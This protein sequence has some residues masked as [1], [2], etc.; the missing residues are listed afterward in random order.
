MIV[1]ANHI[2][3]QK[4]HTMIYKGSCH[5]GAIAFEANGDIPQVIECNCSI[6]RR[7]GY[8]LWFVPRD[9][10]TLNKAES[11]MGTYTFNRHMIR[12]HFCPKCGVATFGMTKDPKGHEMVAI[13]V[14]CLEDVDLSTVKRN[15]Y[16][17]RSK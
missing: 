12:H 14:R 1:T 7:H 9:K 8:L 17:G 13:N 6:C 5:C 11:E 4:R 16:D 3:I 2:M 10:V 15:P